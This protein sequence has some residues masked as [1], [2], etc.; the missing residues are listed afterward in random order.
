M[1]V[2][3]AQVRAQRTAYGRS[4]AQPAPDP[5]SRAALPSAPMP[6]DA[7]HRYITRDTPKRRVEQVTG[8]PFTVELA[9]A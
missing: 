8:L 1:I 9:V 6:R 3:D 2:A 5:R 4:R 7:F